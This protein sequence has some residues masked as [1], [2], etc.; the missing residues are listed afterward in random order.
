MRLSSITAPLEYNNRTLKTDDDSSHS[1][2]R[3]EDGEPIKKS[4]VMYHDDV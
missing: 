1:C 2:C 4:I 3:K